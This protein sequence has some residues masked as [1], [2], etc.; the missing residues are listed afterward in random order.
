MSLITPAVSVL[1]SMLPRHFPHLLSALLFCILF[2]GAGSKPRA[3]HMLSIHSPQRATFPAFSCHSS[4]LKF[5]FKYCCSKGH[6]IVKK[7]LCES[8]RWRKRPFRTAHRKRT[9]VYKPYAIVSWDPVSSG[10]S[11]Y[12]TLWHSLLRPCELSPGTSSQS[13]FFLSML[14]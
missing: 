10:H 11:G 14:Y 9:E 8:V 7:S 12:Q 3:L 1:S 4:F 2:F 6:K 5:Q 13:S